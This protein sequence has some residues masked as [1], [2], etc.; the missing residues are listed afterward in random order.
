MSDLSKRIV[1]LSPEQRGVLAKKLKMTRQV[2]SA[3]SNRI[4]TSRRPADLPLSYAQQ[5]LWFLDQLRPGDTTYNIPAA[6]RL[7]G[8]LRV[9]A[10]QEALSEI[11]RRHEI[12]R[13]TFPAVDGKPRQVISPAQRIHLP[14]VSLTHLSEDEREQEARRFAVTE[15]RRSF[16]LARGP[17][18]RLV[19][20]QIDET[21]HVLLMTMHHIITDAWSL[22]IMVREVQE[23]YRACHDGRPAM[24]A[25]MKIQ[26]ADYAL[27]Q[28]QP[29]HQELF[30]RQLDY[31]KQ[32]LA[33]LP[34]LLDLPT[35]RPRTPVQSLRGSAVDFEL[36]EPLTRA[37]F[38][39]QQRAGATLFMVLLAGLAALLH[40]YTG[41]HDITIGTD[42]ANRHWSETEGLIGF[43]INQLALRT[44]ISGDPAFSQ[45][46][47]RVKDRT[48]DAFANQDL[49]FEQLVAALQPERSLSHVPIFQ[50][51]LVV[52]NTPV[53]PVRLTELAI[54]P[55]AVHNETVG[56]DLIL[57]VIESPGPLQG[58]L[59]YH[60]DIFERTTIERLLG[61]YQAI[62]E[63]ATRDPSQPI[64]RLAIIPSAEARG[65]LQ[66]FNRT[67]AAL[68][69]P[70]PC[71]HQLFEQQA[72]VAPQRTA[73]IAG[74]QSLSYGDLNS[75]ANQLAHYLRGLGVGPE[76]IVGLCLERSVEMVVS[77]LGVL[78]AGGAYLP[79]D[80]KYPPQRLAYM[81]DDSAVPVLLTQQHLLD[82]LPSVWSQVIC[83]E[84][85]AE[86]IARAS[87]SNL[88]LDVSPRN[89]AYVIYTSG[90]T[91]KPKGV[92]VEHYGIANL[93]RW[94]AHQFN[95]TGKSRISQF[96]SYSFDAAVGETCMALLNGA[97]LVM[98]ERED[99]GAHSLIDAINRHRISVLVLVP[100]LLKTL[101]AAALEH[102]EQLTIVAVGEAC[103]PELASRWSR[104]CRFSNAYGP[105]EYTVYSHLWHGTAQEL[106]NRAG[107]V[108]VGFPIFNTKTYILDAQL[109]PVPVGVTGEIYISGAG[110]ARG[111]LH[112][113]GATATRFLPNPFLV[114]DYFTEHDRLEAETA[115]VEIR[116]FERRVRVSPQPPARSE[117]RDWPRYISPLMIFKLIDSLSPDLIKKTHAFITQHAEASAEYGAF[118]RYL[119][120]GVNGSY[121]SCGINSEVLRQ[122]LP[123]E[124]FAGLR[125]IDF[126]FG[127]GEILKTLQAMGAQVTGLDFNP[128]FVQKARDASLQAAMVKVD[129]APCE[130]A[131]TCGIEP[132]SQD[133]AVSTLLL[134]RL[135][136]PRNMLENFFM[137]LKEGGRFAI[138][139]LLP[140]VGVDD[141]DVTDPLT[142]TPESA[143]LVPG[144]AVEEDK[145]ALVRLLIALGADG[146]A[147]YK[148]PYVVMSRDGLQ[149]YV[150]WS[151]TGVRNS[152]AAR[153]AGI[154]RCNSM[155][156]TGDRGRFLRGGE[157]EFRGRIDTQ[158]KIRGYRI[159]LGEIEAAVSAHSQ[160]R[161]CA[162]LALDNPQ[163]GQRL[164]AYVV[165]SGAE[166]S[167]EDELASF[168]RQKLPGFM[169]PSTFVFLERLP[170]LP[171][172]KIAYD[173]LPS[174]GENPPRRAVSVPPRNHFERV[175]A[176]AWRDVLNL[177]TVGIHDNI[178]EL[179]GDSILILQ[180]LAKL[181]QAGIHLRT[182]HF[183]EHQT[184]ARLAEAHLESASISAEQSLI[185]GEVRLAPVQR[186]FFEQQLAEPHH[187][188]Q[189]IM[190]QARGTLDARLL[191]Q[192]CRSL[193]AHHDALR[194]C[195]RRLAA[196]WEQFNAAAISHEIFTCQQMTAIDEH[197]ARQQTRLAAA[198]LQA[199]LN[200]ETGSLIKARLLA[201]GGRMP[202][203]LLIVI[204]HLA[205]DGVSWR[206]LL[207]DLH[208][209]YSQLLREE[210]VALP[211][212]TT[213]W[214]TWTERLH[215]CASSPQLSEDA[216]YWLAMSQ[217]QVAE[218]PVDFRAGENSEAAADWAGVTLTIEQTGELLEQ[219]PKIWRSAVNEVLLAAFAQTVS[220]W[221]GGGPVLFDVEGHGRE[222]LFEGV[223][224]SRTVGWFTALYPALLDVGGA[225]TPIESIAIAK[226]VL[227]TIPRRG[228]SYGL[229]RYSSADTAVREALR[230]AQPAAISFNYL[231]QFDRTLKDSPLFDR[232]LEVEAP[233]RS[234]GQQRRYLLEVSAFIAAKQLHLG[235]RFSR[236]LHR[237][238]TIEALLE[239][240]ADFI[241]A[242]LA[243]SRHP[244]AFAL[245]PGDFPLAERTLAK[246]Q[247]R[248]LS[249]MFESAAP[250]ENI[251]P[252][253][254]L[255]QGL[256]YHSLVAA[257]SGVY[258]NQISCELQGDLAITAFR[259]AWQ[260]VARRHEIFR[261]SYV[262]GQLAEP[263]AL[264]R[265]G[266]ALPFVTED[267]RGATDTGLDEKLT[268]CLDQDRW[269]GFDLAS[270]PLMRLGLLR[271]GATS[272]R[273][274][275]SFHHLLL[276]GWSVYLVL[277]EVFL[278]YEQACKGVRASLEPAV[279]Y[280]SYIEW[281][282]KQDISQ[283]E[284]FWRK[285]LRGAS[286]S[287]LPPMNPE[288]AA[289]AGRERV[290]ELQVRL[291]ATLTA[292]L[293]SLA[294][295][296][297][298]TMNTIVQGAWALLQGRYTNS[299]DVIF[300]AV[301]SGR[302]ASLRGIEQAVGL[303][304]NTLPV[305]ARISRDA[306]V[307]E[308]LHALQIQQ[309][310]TSDYEYSP[311]VQ[312]QGWSDVPRA[313][314]LFNVILA[315]ENYPISSSLAAGSTSFQI[316]G[317]RSV[318]QTNYPITVLVAP[319]ESLSVRIVFNQSQF[320]LPAVER[321]MGHFEAL[322]GAIVE[323]PQA[324]LCALP[325]LSP[326]ERLT[327]L[328]EWN[329]TAAALP[330]VETIPQLFALQA[331]QRPDRLALACGEQRRSYGQLEE[332][333][334]RL[335]RFLR[336]QGVGRGSLVGISLPRSVPMVEAVLG[337]MK[338]GAAYVPLDPSYPQARL[339]LMIEDSG[340]E[341]LLG[342]KEA[343]WA[344][345]I[346]KLT[347]VVD[348][349]RQEREIAK[350]EASQPAV[351]ICGE[352]AAYVIYTSGSTG[353]PKGVVG[354]HRGAVNRFNWMWRVY[355]FE[356]GEV[357]CQKTA[358]SFVDSLWEIFGPL[359]QAVSVV[360]LPQ[361]VVN[362]PQRLIEALAAA[363]VT[364]I[365]LVPSLLRTLLDA[366]PDLGARL[367]RLKYW[368]SSGE[369]LPLDLIERFGR[370]LPAALLLNLYGSSEV[371]ADV[372]FHEISRPGRAV[373][374]SLIGRPI[375]NTQIYLLDRDMTPVPPGVP[376]ELY[377]GGASLAQGYLHDAGLTAQQFVA[378]P[379][380]G[381]EGA[382]LFRTGD[383]ARYLPDGHLEYLGRVDHQVKVRGFRIELG[384]VE[385]ALREH[386]AIRE[387]VVAAREDEPGN[388]R[389]VAY[390]VCKS[391]ACP[392]A[393][394]L[395]NFLK[396][397][398]Q[399]Y[400]VPA[401]FIELPALPLT[402]NGKVDRL[403]LPAPDRSRSDMRTVL[404]A[405]R[406]ELER[407]ISEIWQEVLNVHAVGVDDNFF[408][409]GG[410]SLLIVRVQGLLQERLGIGLPVAE[411]FKYPTIGSLAASIAGAGETQPAYRQS[412][413]RGKRRK[414]RR[415]RHGSDVS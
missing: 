219:A 372:T 43:F 59:E 71:L 212:K 95:L 193:V 302:P 218:P 121:A 245:S 304:I 64:S 129:L 164:V 376:G 368:V 106:A 167:S 168:L 145:L 200:L 238:A 264:V 320:D 15:G 306:V 315:F 384:D 204:H 148:L 345:G 305:R 326:R 187:Y 51:K 4:P 104:R 84:A 331:R 206:I 112:N 94:Q 10:L 52:Q 86:E 356:P 297:R 177:E 358:L 403:A 312:V 77:V 287:H 209:L 13:T 7:R 186:W 348:A 266:V 87:T 226:Q 68:P 34:P 216:A 72:A 298:L 55:F 146:I 296:H 137:V 323:S 28:R 199:S 241:R 36:P 362:D 400:L 251:H 75:R 244:Q 379:Y 147:V 407:K 355:P 229:L 117:P 30:A 140:I 269:R 341:V 54:E 163:G 228:L 303:F 66:E 415:S 78:K 268:S 274:F 347:R 16:D 221:A 161:D 333:S 254:P 201:F 222:D 327:L 285:V 89:L 100:S 267:W 191:D 239:G 240:A 408:E 340:M 162:V 31:W 325:M 284:T 47:D 359:L 49:P 125:G 22:G 210:A 192:A 396:S 255:Q 257:E 65:L 248:T 208:A 242:S 24:L 134:D 182:S 127:N 366:V 74:S 35:D 67:R 353:R 377:V 313:V 395:R 38:E 220:V 357:C 399:D 42:I 231:G 234:P 170:L 143:R 398:L 113:P 225:P 138:Q 286:P 166:P 133:F 318:E 176:E 70:L 300:G 217:Q 82:Q 26:Y 351:E 378:D 14:L 155:Y 23:L 211:P 252:L 79:L 250:L 17:L 322:L 227:R 261:T 263:L 53:E 402:P 237:R 309:V 101:D 371:S 19:L 18:L 76:V 93:I 307:L 60:T 389:L 365:V 194:L 115:T 352:D 142:Y 83:L 183:F 5:R 178:F 316:A 332:N 27:W 151:F 233:D 81:L 40:R 116:Q 370:A 174:P 62:L 102:P 135:A 279:P 319:G 203:R 247:R 276:D 271:T 314:P 109:H 122:L 388:Q 293:Q 197:Q 272:Y 391:S 92:A 118:S 41:Q 265:Q 144:R 390:Y 223:D 158:V 338:A 50:V 202:D 232:A 96:A 175:V 299:D 207:E 249:G 45:L 12:L 114:Y 181:N 387:L 119:L 291:S 283:A 373:R 213:S 149:E 278:L 46:L 335:A 360:V 337:V 6:V 374:N 190:L 392:Q 39:V 383:I 63:S 25:E 273:F 224:A 154:E 32:Q 394:E 288:R 280:A 97:T 21:D 128:V 105:T 339:R 308:W 361:E 406:T 205:V 110:L 328:R 126:G 136:N 98:I 9:Q 321:M 3:G 324:P 159:E 413:E 180:I 33:Q 61:H 310:E 235:I 85:A 156:K 141:G 344:E 185:S 381:R 236:H 414:A 330:S 405:P 58:V 130:F 20:L 179:G 8:R 380:S 290:G 410:Q 350:E 256:L 409:L 124:K 73:V 412:L 80:P 367:P 2:S 195:F 44:D 29:F 397:R 401:A 411:L 382:R 342:D 172:G 132:G 88:E 188:N 139:T 301:V 48:L 189:S 281:L 165:M 336:R 230:A 375:A 157:I 294:R 295:Q 277:A 1:S 169:V 253:A 346:G 369:A 131:G 243:Q 108:P 107:P 184:I 56:F 354:L 99:L 196:G 215:A 57:T 214:Q 258:V 329:E 282:G 364:R 152:E 90:S 259:E 103:P 385:A 173:R 404:T 120:E 275:W 349:Q 150:V 311:L 69:E 317:V 270:A 160:I 153:A 343:A 11:V 262:W 334:N 393:S 198:E 292:R 246:L 171:N 91:G 123:F 111:Y 260:E 289:S 37:I 386:P 363:A